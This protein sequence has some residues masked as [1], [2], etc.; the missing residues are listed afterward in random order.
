[1][2]DVSNLRMDNCGYTKK[3]KGFV[4]KNKTHF[5]EYLSGVDTRANGGYVVIPP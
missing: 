5:P 1:N 3:L 2:D 4:S